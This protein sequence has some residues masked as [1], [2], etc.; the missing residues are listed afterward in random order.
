MNAPDILALV[1]ISAVVMACNILFTF[2]V[3]YIRKRRKN[4]LSKIEMVFAQQVSEYLY[5]LENAPVNSIHISRELRRV[6]IKE[7]KTGNIQFLIQLMITTQRVLGGENHHKIKKLYGEIPPYGFSIAK[8]RSKRWSRIAQGIR[9]IY[10]MDQPQY[11]KEIAPFYDHKN[12]FVRREAQIAMVVFLGWESLRFLPYLKQRISLWQQIKIV[13]K[14]HDIDKTPRLEYLKRNYGTENSEVLQLIIRII[15]KYQIF[16]ESDFLV[17]MLTNKDYEVREA[18]IY[19][20][21]SLS[22]KDTKMKDLL[23]SNRTKIPSQIQ[24]TQLLKYLY[25]KPNF[26]K[27]TSELQIG[28]DRIA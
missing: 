9:E 11:L 13:E 15:K 12:K 18:A 10:E 17:T 20:L 27:V 24:Q 23:Y 21:L 6:G 2:L 22:V 1:R 4:R 5:P 3:M 7:G 28:L 14:L 25:K 19:A 16:S 8:I 26:S